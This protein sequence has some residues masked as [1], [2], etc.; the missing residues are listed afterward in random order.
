LLFKNKATKCGNRDALQLE[1]AR[2]RASR[3]VLFLTK[4]VLCIRTNC[5]FQVSCQNS[6][7]AIRFGDI[8]FLKI[9]IIWRS[10]R[11]RF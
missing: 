4:F 8:H 5:Y 3:S 1:A 10:D 7:I 6:D 9:A 11:R 2:R